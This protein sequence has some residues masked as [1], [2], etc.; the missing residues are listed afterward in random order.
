[1]R[2]DNVLCCAAADTKNTYHKSATPPAAANVPFSSYNIHHHHRVESNTNSGNSVPTSPD[3]TTRDLSTR[4]DSE[5]SKP[6]N[7]DGRISLSD[8][9]PPEGLG[10][11]MVEHVRRKTGLSHDKSQLAVATVL[12]LLAERVPA[13]EKLATAILDDS[14]HQQVCVCSSCFDD[15]LYFSVE[16]F[17]GFRLLDVQVVNRC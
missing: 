11:V 3:V 16:F 17:N 13:T 6:V 12:H 5:Q 1:M 8:L 4:L 7:F 9:W 14:R 15:F 10:A 2:C